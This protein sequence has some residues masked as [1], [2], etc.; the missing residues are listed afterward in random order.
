MTNE[1]RKYYRE[2]RVDL[3]CI[4]DL[5]FRHFRFMLKN[6][7]F[8]KIND[9]I[10]NEEILRKWL[11]VYS[12]LDVYYSTSCFLKP[13]I[14]GRRELTP[15][16]AN[17]FLSSDIVFDI[18]RSPFSKRN[19]EKARK[20]TLNLIDF[21]EQKNY[22]IKYLAFSGSKGFHAVF[23]DPYRYEENDPLKREDLAKDKRKSIIQMI[24]S[25]G[26]EVDEKITIDTRRIIRVPGTINSKTGFLCTTLSKNQ[27]DKP[28]GEI[29]KYV[30]RVKINAPMISTLGNENMLC[31]I[32]KIPGPFNRIGVRLGPKYCYA[33]FLTNCVPGIKRSIPFF[34]FPLNQSTKIKKIENK[35][36]EIQCNY[37]LSD[38]YLFKS[39]SKIT[40]ISLRTFQLRRLE[41]IIKA[42][43]SINYNSLVKYKQLFFRV[44]SKK[45]HKR[46][47]LEDSP[48]YVKTIKADEDKNSNFISKPHLSFFKS[49][50][51]PMRWYRF[52]H[53]KGDVFLVYAIIEN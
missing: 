12:P 39:E 11:L 40:A 22:E 2:A 29:L 25:E 21:L 37:N 33:S 51:I 47:I 1:I 44:G 36:A 43:S 8:Q 17:L 50:D 7:R 14:L 35:L 31:I 4:S 26:M 15:L 53:G 19:L 5:S 9:R 13:E 23:K 6:G 30:P 46:R 34:E 10:R 41:K 28:V 32:R 38:I 16:S 49:F 27:I 45:D 42:S 48:K 3:G 24:Q 18:D 20:E 52:M